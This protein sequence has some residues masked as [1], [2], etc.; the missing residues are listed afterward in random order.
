MAA[1]GLRGRRPPR[2]MRTTTPEPTPPAI[3]DRVPGEFVAATP[4]V[5]WVGT[6]RTCARWEGWLYLAT[7]LDVF[8]RRII[9]WA[10]ADHLRP[11]L[12]CDALRMAIATRGGPVAG[13]L[14]HP[15]KGCQYTSAEFRALCDAHGVQQSMGRTGVCWDHALA[16]SFFATYKLELI[17]RASWPTRARARTTVHWLEAIYN[18]RRRYSAIDEN[19]LASAGREG[20]A[21]VADARRRGRTLSRLDRPDTRASFRT[22]GEV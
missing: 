11:S 7:V 10:L 13:V 22:T 4:D 6:S 21:R 14:F 9:G 2:W 20:L 5:L 3:P 1:A 15:D 16:E 17:E 18:R 12:A 8:S 19:D